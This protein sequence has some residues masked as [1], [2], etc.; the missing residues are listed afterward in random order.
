MTFWKKKK[1]V[2]PGKNRG[3]GEFIDN[4][5][6]WFWNGAAFPGLISR[7]QFSRIA[8]RSLDPVERT[9]F[10]RMLVADLIV[11]N[12]QRHKRS[13]TEIKL[14][15]KVGRFCETLQ[16]GDPD[17]TQTEF[18]DDTFSVLKAYL[19]ILEFWGYGYSWKTVKDIR[20]K[21]S[22]VIL[23]NGAEIVVVN[24][25][26]IQYISGRP[27]KF[28]VSFKGMSWCF[29]ENDQGIRV[30]RRVRNGNTLDLQESWL[31]K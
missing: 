25:G 30:L 21:E 13:P 11:T 18:L 8:D 1:P 6:W 28:E 12:G 24:N 27:F 14:L 3:T 10:S 23:K 2:T 20:D 7:E 16:N 22:I 31:R 19:N 5:R 26:E 4:I 15:E 29:D 17:A 9:K